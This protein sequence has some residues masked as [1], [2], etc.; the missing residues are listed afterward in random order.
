MKK[1]YFIPIIMLAVLMWK[2]AEPTD[3]HDAT[4]NVPP[5]SVNNVKVENLPGGAIITYTLPS[6]NDVMGAKVVYSLSE[7]GESMERFASTDSLELEDYGD[8]NEHQVTVYAIDK[9]GNVSAG[10]PVTIRPHSLPNRV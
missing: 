1:L 6:D 10:T 9:S 2:C 4:D 7:E 5:G 3:W 8:T